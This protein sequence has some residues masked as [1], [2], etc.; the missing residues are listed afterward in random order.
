MKGTSA[1]NIEMFSYFVLDEQERKEAKHAGKESITQTHGHT[2]KR[3]KES[4][5]KPASSRA[6][7]RHDKKTQ[8]MLAELN[9]LKSQMIE[10]QQSMHRP[11][12]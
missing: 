2:D 8:Q 1:F 5:S 3:S 7:T 12:V 4:S 10:F 9:R 11:P 6:S